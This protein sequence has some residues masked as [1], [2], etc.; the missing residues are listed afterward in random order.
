MIHLF[1][2]VESF[3]GT[4]LIPSEKVRRL[5]KQ[6]HHVHTIPFFTI[7][8]GYTEGIAVVNQEGESRTIKP[9]RHQKDR[10]LGNPREIR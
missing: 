6:R 3:G 1:V 10:I 9:N 7:S 4:C 8:N 2:N 5:N